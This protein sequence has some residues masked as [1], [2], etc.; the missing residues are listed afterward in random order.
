MA[1]RV[2]ADGTIYVDDM[3]VDPVLLTDGYN[4]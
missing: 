4:G 3:K 2:E 1:V